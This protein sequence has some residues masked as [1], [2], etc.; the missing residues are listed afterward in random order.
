MST[1]DLRGFEPRDATEETTTDCDDCA[2]M[3][4]SFP[5][6]ECYLAGAPLPEA[7]R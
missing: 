6:F 3:H 4:G 1:E 5:C 7:R 2:A